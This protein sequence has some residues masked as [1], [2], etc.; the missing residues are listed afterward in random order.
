M[1]ELVNQVEWA[2]NPG[3]ELPDTYRNDNY[4]RRRAAGGT[5]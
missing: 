4:G 2:G 3:N 1:K 5:G